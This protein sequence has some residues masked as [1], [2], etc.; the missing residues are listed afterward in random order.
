MKYPGLTVFL[1]FFGISL[2]D[3]LSGGHWI[4]A[5]FWIGIGLAFVA[6]DRAGRRRNAKP[7]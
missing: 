3:A 7:T 1:V 4:R 6:L 5:F 2:L